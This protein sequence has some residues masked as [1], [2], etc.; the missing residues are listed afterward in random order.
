M[1]SEALRLLD[2]VAAGKVGVGTLFLGANGNS[3]NSGSKHKTTRQQYNGSEDDPGLMPMARGSAA[4]QWPRSYQPVRHS[5]G[6]TEQDALW[7]IVLRKLWEQRASDGL[8]NEFLQ[9]M[10]PGQLQRFKILY[11]LQQ[12]LEGGYTMQPLDDWQV[13][14]DS[15]QQEDISILAADSEAASVKEVLAPVAASADMSS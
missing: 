9:R 14:A 10:S 15:R 1:W 11:N 4:A 2:D 8:L 7:H 12:A 6:T 3:T 13:P 5:A